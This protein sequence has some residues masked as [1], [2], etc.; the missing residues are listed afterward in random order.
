MKKTVSYFILSLF[1]AGFIASCIK[2]DIPYPKSVGEILSFQVQG[3]IGDAVI[4]KEKLSVTV[5]V[6]DT[7]NLTKVKLIKMVV[8]DNATFTPEL[9]EF[10][11][12]TTT[13]SY[14]LS[15][16]PGQS[17]EWKIVAVQNIN[18]YI[19]ADNQ[20]SEAEFNVDE[21]TAVFY[22]SSPL[23]KVKINDIQLGPSNS[24]I[25]PDPRTIS[26]FSA[27]VSVTVSYRDVSENWTINA[28]IREAQVT[29][30][31]ADAFANHVYLKGTF[32]SGSS[33]PTFLYR[34][35]SDSKWSSVPSE[36]LS[37][38]G[39]TIS[40]HLTGLAPNTEYLF[41]T[42]VGESFG[43]EVSFTTEKDLQMPNMGF[44]NWVSTLVNNKNTWFP[45]LDMSDNYW[46][47]SG[48]QGA[49]TLGEANPTSPESTFV[50]KGKASRMETVSVVGQMAGGNVFSGKFV[51]TI[52]GIK[53]G[54]MVDFGRPF[55]SRPSK[56]HGY[57]SYEPAII[58]KVKDPYKG[59]L[60][61]SDRFHI[62]MMLFD[63]DKPYSV[64]TAEGTY[65][66]PFSDN[67]VI[68][69]AELVDSV[70]TGGKYKE[71]TIDV[72]YKDSRK[73]GYCALV[74]VGSYYADYFTGGVGTLLY[75]DEFSFIYDADVKW[76]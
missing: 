45:N 58:N 1:F 61:R 18:R 50:V 39:T 40:A 64:N 51:K 9:S 68:G 75:A 17:Y 43:E 25:T 66:P 29:T 7:V 76:E 41:K 13:L 6:A 60:G 62:F 67:C 32:V 11:D 31:T 49:N 56:I 74:A 48:N 2:N 20:V 16:Y 65:L 42:A 3:Q 21:K 23:D 52:I 46:W 24:V 15:T 4:D 14:I 36:M 55:T 19:K 5:E 63:Q 12:L 38:E 44:D 10:I 26:D 22:V 69:Y 72:T 54:A 73:P 8:S 34:K 35:S 47:D 57:Y 59:L 28:Y 27:R 71:F 33:N 53:M 70:S 37:I 30:G